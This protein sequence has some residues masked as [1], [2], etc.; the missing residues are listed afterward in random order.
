ML[1]PISQ[2]K[3]FLKILVSAHFSAFDNVNKFSFNLYSK[4]DRKFSVRRNYFK[5]QFRKVILN[6]NVLDTT[7]SNEILRKVVAPRSNQSDADV[8]S[9]YLTKSM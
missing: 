7:K 4:W 1:Q 6:Y 9:V 3:F 5:K 8:N 2:S